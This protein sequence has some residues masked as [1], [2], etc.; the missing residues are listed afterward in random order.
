VKKSDSNSTKKKNF[1]KVPTYPG[2]K[3][4]FLD[5]ITKNLVYPQE[6]IDNSIEGIV[7]I[8]YDVDNI[9]NVLNVFVKKGIGFGCDDEAI[10]VVQMLEYEPVRNRGVRMK[11]RMKSR[12]MFKL[13]VSM[14]KQTNN[15]I[16]INYIT[17]TPEI[18]NKQESEDKPAY[19]YTIT[20]G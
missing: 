20:I 2:G 8:E 12:I 17:N 11:T 19:S 6:A 3:Q 13:P 10:R 16:Q 4:A 1:L 7:F 18:K 14:E 5:F 9:G 15:S